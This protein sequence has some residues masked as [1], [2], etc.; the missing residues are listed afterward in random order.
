MTLNSLRVQACLFLQKA[1]IKGVS[2]HTWFQILFKKYNPDS[3]PRTSRLCFCGFYMCVTSMSLFLPDWLHL[4]RHQSFVSDGKFCPALEISPGQFLFYVILLSFP[5]WMFVS[6]KS[7]G[8]NPGC[9]EGWCLEGWLG[10][11]R[12]TFKNGI[13][14]FRKRASASPLVFST[15]RG[16]W[17]QQSL[18]ETESRLTRH[19]VYWNLILNFLVSKAMRKKGYCLLGT[20]CVVVSYGGPK[21]WF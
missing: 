7:R 17:K 20:S 15:M 16:H 8:L 5:D 19:P 10:R 18:C 1:E 11:M 9:R 14:A 6:S 12:V 13:N 21:V 4:N 2:H 3:Q